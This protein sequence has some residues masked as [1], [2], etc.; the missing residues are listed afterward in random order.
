MHFHNDEVN[1]ANSWLIAASKIYKPSVNDLYKDSLIEA[2]W[3][4]NIE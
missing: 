2:G 3:I 4:E 1:E